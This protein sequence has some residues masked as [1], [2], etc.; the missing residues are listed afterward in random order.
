MELAELRSLQAQAAA[1]RVDMPEL[2][3]L[4]AA[5][6]RVGVWQVG[7]RGDVHG[8]VGLG[9]EAVGVPLSVASGM[10]GWMFH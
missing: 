8:R 3:S 7:W 5:M 9:G 1:L 2:A 6:E 10:R 4:A